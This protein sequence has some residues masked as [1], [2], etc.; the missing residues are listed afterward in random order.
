MKETLRSLALV[1]T[2]AVCGVGAS[3]AQDAVTSLEDLL[4]QV[5][6]QGTESAAQNR[7]REQEFRQRRDEQ[8]AILER[9]RSE[10]RAQETRSEQLKRSF[11]ANEKELEELNETLRIRVGDLGEL[12][13]VVR[14]VA[15]DTKGIVESS[16]I[17]AQF[18]NRSDVATELAQATQLPSIADLRALQALLLEEMIE[19]GKVAR[20]GAEVEDAAGFSAPAEVVRIGVFNA[21]SANGYLTFD[22]AD[23]SLRELP[24]PPAA[25]FVRSAREFFDAQGDEASMAIDPTRGTLL[26]LVIQAPGFAEQV[27]QGGA[28]G[29]TIIAMGIIG[30]LIAVGRLLALQFEGKKIRRQLLASSASDDNSLGRILSVYESEKSV[31]A[32]ALD[33]KLDE[34]ILREIPRLER[35]QGLIKVIAG[36]APLL[37]LLGTVVGMIKTFQS[38]TLFGTGDP[39]L[40]ADGISQALV[41]T[42][43]GLVV[44]IPMV[45]MH[46]L[47]SGKSRAL[48]EV[49]EEQSAGLIARRAE[50]EDFGS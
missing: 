44:A 3:F 11:D 24:R 10:L 31:S 33:M 15:G 26:S 21:I 46:A 6:E 8:K 23:Q 45:F 41:T 13:G 9:T 29:Y 4:K 2:V 17:S 32:D 18:A 50:Q 14:Q 19:S 34:A 36:V 27:N 43:E 16:L 37:G 48:I 40:M 1:L 28:V 38:I 42:V 35:F 5:R 47:I 49:L 30:L 25:R 12:F 20:F 22:E 7:Q 39:K